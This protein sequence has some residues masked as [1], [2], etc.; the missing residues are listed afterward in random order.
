MHFLN[1]KVPRWIILSILALFLISNSYYTYVNNDINARS[2]ISA[3]ALA[4]ISFLTAQSLFVYKPHSIT[5]SAILLSAAYIIRGSFFCIPGDCVPHSIPD[6]YLFHPHYDPG[7]DVFIH[8]HYQL[9]GNNWFDHHGQPA[10]E[11]GNEGSQRT[12]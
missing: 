8:S 12:L 11:H 6:Y 5:A 7:H 10:F 4:I 9:A 2:V 3:V 1:K